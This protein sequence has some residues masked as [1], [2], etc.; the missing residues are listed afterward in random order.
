MSPFLLQLK[1]Y[2]KWFI[3]EQKKKIREMTDQ[4]AIKLCKQLDASQKSFMCTAKEWF[5]SR[6][7][8]ILLDVRRLQE[9][10]RQFE[11]DSTNETNSSESSDTGSFQ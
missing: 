7:R 3:W 5:I 2:S 4:F 11:E 8:R 10:G 1:D 9:E 6:K